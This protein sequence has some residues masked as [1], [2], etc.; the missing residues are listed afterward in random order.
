MLTKGDIH[1][2]ACRACYFISQS[3]DESPIRY[4]LALN[5]QA[6]PVN[7]ECSTCYCYALCG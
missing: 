4:S 7:V 5:N 6:A 3:A 2:L 1:T